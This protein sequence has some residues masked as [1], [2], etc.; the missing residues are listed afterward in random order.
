MPFADPEAAKAY[1]ASYRETHREQIRENGRKYA[2][3]PEN[4]LAQR[5][6]LLKRRYGITAEQFNELWSAQNGKCKLCGREMIADGGISADRV[7][8]DHNHRTEEVRAL[9]H[10]KCNVRLSN[11]EDLDFALKAIAYLRDHGV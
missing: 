5:S 1:H 3:N 10:H 8:V 7:V 6:R 9:L 11:I 2:A 4:K